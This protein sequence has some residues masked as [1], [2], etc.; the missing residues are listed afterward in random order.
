MYREAR[1][2][3]ARGAGL[4]SAML[5][6]AR[7][8]VEVHVSS[9]AKSSEACMAGGWAGSSVVRTSCAAS[10]DSCPRVGVGLGDWAGEAD[11]DR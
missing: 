5:S 1:V 4:L 11:E 8:G 10:S 7:A 6:W 9:G 2:E 3:W